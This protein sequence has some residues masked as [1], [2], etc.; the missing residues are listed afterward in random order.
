MRLKD[1]DIKELSDLFEEALNRA[2]RIDRQQKIQLR[3]KIRNELFSMLGWE[4]AT[5]SSV[6]SR[7][8]ER[9]A[10]IFA[11][12]PYGFKDDLNRVLVE[13]MRSPLRGSGK[14]DE[15]DPLKLKK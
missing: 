8:E 14:K 15:R 5:A 7:W 10:E 2:Q 12:L 9:L 6:M 1:P 3:K 4:T 11:V 13:K